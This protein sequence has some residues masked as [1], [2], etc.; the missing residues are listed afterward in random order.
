VE[1][2]L[3][4]VKLWYDAEGDYMEVL[5]DDR[6]PGYFRETADERVMKKVDAEG[7]VLGFSV[8]AAS[9]FEGE[10]LE[11]ALSDENATER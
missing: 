10:P 9:S 6:T 3:R 11:V 4:A 7:N 1:S 8:L 5:F 2:T